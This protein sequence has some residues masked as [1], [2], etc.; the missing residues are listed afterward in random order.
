VPIQ[1]ILFDVGGPIDT[2]AEHE[3]LIDLAIRDAV[4]RNGYPADDER[5]EAANTYAITSF[6]PDAYAAIAWHLCNFDAAATEA[7][8]RDL[9]AGSAERNAQRGGLELRPGIATLLRRLTDA[10]F[11]LGLAA[12]QPERVVEELDRHGIGRLFSHREVTGHPG[13]RKPDPR[14]FLRALEDL[15]VEPGEAIMVG[16]R[17]DNDI[18]PA[19][20]LGM[21]AI[22]FRTGRHATQQ[23]RSPAELPH[24]EVST[25]EAL[26]SALVTLTA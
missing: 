19:R 3:R 6:A 5:F 23:P 2:E 10:G 11:R 26:E 16:D 21:R 13:Y 15:A 4:A 14:L 18:V 1:A 17:I 12:N 24:Q 9:H 7:V 8:L 25:I 22:L 20:L